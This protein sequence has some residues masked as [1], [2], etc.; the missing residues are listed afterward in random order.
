MN[1]PVSVDFQF[2]VQ[3]RGR[4][5]KKRIVEGDLARP[6]GHVPPAGTQIMNLRLFRPDIRRRTS[7]G[8]ARR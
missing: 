5:A 4:G 6:L 7:I 8:I 2:S 3:Q 1:K